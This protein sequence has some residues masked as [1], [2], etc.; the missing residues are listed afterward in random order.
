MTRKKYDSYRHAMQSGG[1]ARELAR[2][3]VAQ[4][5]KDREFG[6][7]PEEVLRDV[8]TRMITSAAG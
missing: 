3:E 1:D 4:I 7:A 8:F 6:L 2:D 5:V